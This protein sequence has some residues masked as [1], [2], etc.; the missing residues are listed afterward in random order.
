MLGE[1]SIAQFSHAK[2]LIVFVVLVACSAKSVTTAAS[3]P[4][5][6]VGSSPV[7]DARSAAYT[8]LS[9]Q[10]YL[11]STSDKISNSEE[12]A[13][14]VNFQAALMSNLQKGWTEIQSL[15]TAM[16]KWLRVKRWDIAFTSWNLHKKEP[17]TR[18]ENPKFFKFVSIIESK[19]P[20]NI[21]KQAEVVYAVLASHYKPDELVEILAVGMNSN[22]KDLAGTMLGVQVTNWIGKKT[23][24]DV[25]DLLK[26]GEIKYGKLFAGQAFSQFVSFVSRSAES[27]QKSDDTLYKI[28]YNSFGDLLWGLLI[29][30]TIAKPGTVADRLVKMQLQKWST[31]KQSMGYVFARL[32]LEAD[33]KLFT[34][35]SGIYWLKYVYLLKREDDAEV[36]RVLEK[37][38][39]NKVPLMLSA[40]RKEG[41]P[42]Q[43]LIEKLQKVQFGNWLNAKR[44][45]KEVRKM[46]AQVSADQN[47]IEKVVSEYAVFKDS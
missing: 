10:W 13:G 24:Q 44:G 31:E 11:R 35:V 23:E 39:H 4:E 28:L 36:L 7:L 37:E 12:R 6:A 30:A 3:T 42:G 16:M 2:V 22:N 38:L 26:L 32:Q 40:A 33:S 25:F 20:G 41:A 5:E 47:L 43:E 27:P 15:R 21:H 18:F 1:T 46:L 17:K 34:S 9:V 19:Y 8:S 29:E 45:E 14:W